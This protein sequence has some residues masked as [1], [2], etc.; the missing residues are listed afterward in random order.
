MS[1]EHIARSPSQPA[2][3]LPVPGRSLN[4]LNAIAIGIILVLNSVALA[5]TLRHWSLA[6]L[7]IGASLTILIIL[8]DRFAVREP[9]GRRLTPRPWRSWRER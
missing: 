3:Q 6:A 4:Y 7:A 1:P 8:S 9:E 2:I 5:A